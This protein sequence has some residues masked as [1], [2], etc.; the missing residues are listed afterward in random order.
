MFQG[1]FEGIL[2]GFEGR[3]EEFKEGYFLER[4]PACILS[5]HIKHAINL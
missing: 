2:E 1:R 4:V 3:V 5:I